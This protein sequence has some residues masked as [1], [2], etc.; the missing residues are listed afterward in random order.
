MTHCTA[1]FLDSCGLG[2]DT[3]LCPANQVQCHC[4]N[5]CTSKWASPSMLNFCVELVLVL[6]PLS[7][8]KL[9]WKC[10]CLLSQALPSAGAVAGHGKGAPLPD[11]SVWAGCGQGAPQGSSGQAIVSLSPIGAEASKKESRGR[12]LESKQWYAEV[13]IFKKSTNP[14]S[15]S[16]WWGHVWHNTRIEVFHPFRIFKWFLTWLVHFLMWGTNFL[17]APWSGNDLLE[18]HLLELSFQ[19]QVHWWLSAE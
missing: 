15:T 1:S 11:T 13:R 5:C 18:F 9:P 17:L 16:H 14:S 12:R 2:G 6:M 7:F 4:C 19:F 8:W 3:P 10:H